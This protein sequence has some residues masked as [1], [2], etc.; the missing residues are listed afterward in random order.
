MVNPD[1]ATKAELFRYRQER[2]GPKRPPSPPRRRRD[3]PV[4]TAL[5]GISAT[6]RKG[7]G[8][9]TGGRNVSKSAAKKAPYQ[10]ED[11]R[12]VP[13]R[14][15][16]RRGANKQRQDV[17]LRERVMLKKTSPSARARSRSG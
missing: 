8:N 7:G 5:P 6:D 10:L 13:S 2:K 4:N 17:Q 15:S 1:M 11:S 16:T 9:S 12:T 14:K 3:T